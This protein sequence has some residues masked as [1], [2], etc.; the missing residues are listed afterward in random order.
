MILNYKL[1]EPQYDFFTSTEKIVG[2]SGGLGSGKSFSLY[3][4]FIF[5][6]VLKYPRALH[7]VGAL[8]NQQLKA[9]SV[10]YI[11]GFLDEIKMDFTYNK[12]DQIIILK[13][14]D[15]TQIH[16]RSQEVANRV[17]SVEYG[18][19]YLE[20]TSYWNE[21]S[22]L[23]FLGRLR[24]KKGS[25]RCRMAFTPNGMNYL[26][27]F[28]IEEKKED[29]RLVRASTYGNKHLPAEYIQLLEG[30]YDSNL[31]KQEL[32]GL[33]FEANSQQIYYMFKRDAHVKE[34]DYPINYIGSDFNVCPLT[35]VCCH[36]SGDTIYVVDE[37]WLENSN[38]YILRDTLL[39]TYDCRNITVVADSTSDSRRTS[40][41]KTDQQILKEG[42]LNI[43]RS[44]NPPVG[45]RYN[46]VNNLLEKKRLFIHPR[47][48]MLIRDLEK[49]CRD[50][51]KPE[52]SHISD[53]LGYLA[54]WLFP[55]KRNIDGDT[56]KPFNL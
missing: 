26:Y 50:N 34:F 21:D 17:R 39:D 1:S 13:N 42:G 11:I 19:L 43:A 4:T 6:E 24:D 52:L 55:I 20:E 9:V 49:M 47:C 54:W 46:C 41:I 8:S 44:R 37:I 16:L 36:I 35:S 45:D 32:H 15:R 14:K 56:D 7:C 40:S 27:E 30:S 53:A 18:S 22:F 38:T 2:L 28:M 10:P 25:M 51:K 23:T 3:F 31:Q 29:R 48:K 33:F 12:S 5:N